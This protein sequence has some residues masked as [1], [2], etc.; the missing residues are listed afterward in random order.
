MVFGNQVTYLADR[1]SLRGRLVRDGRDNSCGSRRFRDG[2]DRRRLGR[3]RGRRHRPAGLYRRPDW[4]IEEDGRDGSRVA[5]PVDRHG[6][7]RVPSRRHAVR[8]HPE[9][10]RPPGIDGPF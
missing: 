5:R 7:H 8:A 3:L 10:E 4:H 2:R 6:V 9:L 1:R